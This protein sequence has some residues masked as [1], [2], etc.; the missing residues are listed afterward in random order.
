MTDADSPTSSGPQQNPEPWAVGRRAD[1]LWTDLAWTSL[2]EGGLR[3]DIV[4]VRGIRTVSASGLC[5]RCGHHS[6][7]TEVL[8]GAIR[9]PWWRRGV[10][11]AP[12]APQMLDVDIRCACDEMHPQRPENEVGCGAIFTVRASVTA[13]S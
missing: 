8:N 2:Q 4:Q 3:V 7:Y 9:S 13:A 11:A 1:P 12:V 10:V 5:P 6:T